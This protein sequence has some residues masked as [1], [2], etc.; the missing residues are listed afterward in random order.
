MQFE[1]SSKYTRKG[2]T[3]ICLLK[4]ARP[5]GGDWDTRYVRV[6]II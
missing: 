2:A 5:S 4:T 6:V 3:Q 1:K